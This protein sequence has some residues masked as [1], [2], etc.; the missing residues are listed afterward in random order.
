MTEYPHTF[1]SSGK[2]G[3]FFFFCGM[4][5]PSHRGKGG[6]L[7]AERPVRNLENTQAQRDRLDARPKGETKPN[8]RRQTLYQ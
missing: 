1:P 2:G 5:M 7:T 6:P 8:A 4:E 3:P